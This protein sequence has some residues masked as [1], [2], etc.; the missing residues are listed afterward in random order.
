[1]GSATRST[2][3]ISRTISRSATADVRAHHG[4]TVMSTIEIVQG[5]LWQFRFG[6]DWLRHAAGS[7]FDPRDATWR[8][9]GAGKPDINLSVGDGISISDGSIL[10]TVPMA[11]T[12]TIA[13][14]RYP[15]NAR[16]TDASGAVLVWRGWIEVIRREPSTAFL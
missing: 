13:A 7:A 6:V 8:V 1:F 12:R 14:G 16:A 5:D 15:Y 3:T 2:A 11:R 10:I 4:A 9:D